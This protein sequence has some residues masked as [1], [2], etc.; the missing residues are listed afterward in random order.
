MATL[1]SVT[2]FVVGLIKREIF[3]WNTYWARKGKIIFKI[4]TVYLK[5]K[6][7][8]YSEKS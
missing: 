1:K 5:S 8:K 7:K 4:N 6:F 2:V 3:E